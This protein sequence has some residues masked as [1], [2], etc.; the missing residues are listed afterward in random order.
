MLVGLGLLGGTALLVA[1]LPPLSL[2]YG[3]AGLSLFGCLLGFPF[4]AAY[5][6]VLRRELL[7]L[8]PLPAG[9]IWHPTRHHAQLDDASR[10]RIRPLFSL[11]ALGFLLIML[12]AGLATVTLATHSR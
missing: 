12:G 4:G 3:A 1:S 5:H 2:L 8:G 7:R 9:W 11:G 6:L 10:A